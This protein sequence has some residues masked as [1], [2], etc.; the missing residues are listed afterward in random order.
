MNHCWNPEIPPPLKRLNTGTV[1]ECFNAAE[2]AFLFP[3][4][5]TL[6]STVRFDKN[7]PQ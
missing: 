4:G 5:S 7:D 3:L 2:M 6:V 1:G